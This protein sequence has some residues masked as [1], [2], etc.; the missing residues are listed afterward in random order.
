M[1]GVIYQRFDLVLR[2]TRDSAGQAIA[3]S[4]AAPDWSQ[5]VRLCELD[6]RL[7]P[8]WRATSQIKEATQKAHALGSFQPKEVAPRIVLEVEDPSLQA[9]NLEDVLS[10]LAEELREQ[11]GM[12]V[13]IVRRALTPMRTAAIDLT[14]PFRIL[15]IDPE[16]EWDVAEVL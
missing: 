11:F 14:L 1:A 3:T 9:E 16:P 8:G 15:Q 12:N 4:P 7:F 2:G 6:L 13:A 5:P 10:D